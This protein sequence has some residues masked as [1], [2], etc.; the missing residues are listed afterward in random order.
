MA[1][2]SATCL[3][4]W[5][6]AVSFPGGLEESIL[7]RSTR[8]WRVRSGRDRLSSATPMAERQSK[9]Q[10]RRIESNVIT[11]VR[12]EWSNAQIVSPVDDDHVFSSCG[13][14]ARR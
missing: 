12:I 6:T 5:A 7:I 14:F 3:R 2:E 8:Y 10:K 13:G 1:C 11:C 9:A 4:Y